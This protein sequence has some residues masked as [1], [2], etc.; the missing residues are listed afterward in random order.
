VWLFGPF[1]LKVENST[2]MQQPQHLKELEASLLVGRGVVV[3]HE[4]LT[5]GLR[6]PSPGGVGAF[7][8]R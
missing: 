8:D 6:V 5:M 4:A 3:H 7:D 2:S 1:L